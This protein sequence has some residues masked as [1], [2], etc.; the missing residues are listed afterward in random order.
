M[1]AS[2][3]A[4]PPRTLFLLEKQIRGSL[5]NLV[6]IFVTQRSGVTVH[7]LRPVSR[8]AEVICDGGGEGKRVCK[9]LFVRGPLEC[10]KPFCNSPH[11]VAPDLFRGLRYA[12]PS[13]AG[14]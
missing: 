11:L 3:A 12:R 13:P 9:D 1:R 5:A 2:W 6:Q 4:R 10:F 8:A 7:N 14:L